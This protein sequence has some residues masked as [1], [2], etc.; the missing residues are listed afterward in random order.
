[1]Y[2]NLSYFTGTSQ[3]FFL[4]PCNQCEKKLYIDY[5]GLIRLFQKKPISQDFTR[6]CN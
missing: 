6:K 1:M 5:I 4:Y 2:G 3:D